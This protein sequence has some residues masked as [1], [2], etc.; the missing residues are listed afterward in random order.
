MTGVIE[1][2]TRTRLGNVKGDTKFH[3]LKRNL[4]K[5]EIPQIK[6]ESVEFVDEAEIPHIQ[7]ESVEFCEVKQNSTD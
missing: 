5:T 2:R 4:W 3:R 7:T 1:Q 6:K